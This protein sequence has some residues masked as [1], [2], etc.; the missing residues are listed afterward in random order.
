MRRFAVTLLALALAH[1]FLAVPATAAS[2]CHTIDAKGAGQGAPPQ[3]GDPPNLQRTVA[4]IRGGGLLQ[5]T[6]EAAFSITDPTPP[7]FTFTGD[8][9]FTTNR[10]MLTVR[11]DGTLDV[12]RGEFAASGDVTGATGKLSGATGTLTF[13]GVQNLL[14]PAG[15]F[16]ETVVGKICVDLG[17]NRRG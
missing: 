8:L 11:L 13:T 16:T 15:S 12:T 17:G 10:A 6:T 14:D 2:S 3:P 1:V 5:G 4:Q 7:V 9:R